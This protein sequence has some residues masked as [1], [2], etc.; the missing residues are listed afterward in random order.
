M[1]SLFRLIPALPALAGAALWIGCSSE[2]PEPGPA[3]ETDAPAELGVYPASIA[4]TK[5]TGVSRW[6]IYFGSAGDTRVL[7]VGPDDIVKMQMSIYT[8]ETEVIVES[9]LPSAGIRRVGA[10][11][12]VLEDSLPAVFA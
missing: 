4:T 1:R 3:I 6:M 11:G 7:G 2:A 10:D 9:I 8:T 5:E 12:T